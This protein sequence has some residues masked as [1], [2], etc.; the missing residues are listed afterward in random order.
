M[1]EIVVVF[2]TR[3]YKKE[4]VMKYGKIYPVSFGVAWGL[5]SGLG[6]MLLCWAGARWG[7]GIPVINHMASVYHNIAPTFVGG[8]WGLLWGFIDFLV[9]GVLVAI[10]YNNTCCCFCPKQE[11]DDE[12]KCCK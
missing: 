8:L 9:F 4:F 6:W 12:T 11:C 10:V 5:I 2:L 1:V 3:W 7:Y